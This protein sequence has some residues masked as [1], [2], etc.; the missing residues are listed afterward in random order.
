[1]PT[2]DFPAIFAEAELPVKALQTDPVQDGELVFPLVPITLIAAVN[3]CGGS[4][5]VST[6]QL[7]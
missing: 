3:Y 2:Q 5:H 1:M 4:R 7:Y 6:L